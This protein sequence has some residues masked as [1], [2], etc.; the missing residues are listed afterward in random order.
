MSCEELFPTA[1]PTP[2]LPPV[3]Q[4]DNN[5]VYTIKAEGEEITVHVT[6][7]ID[8]RVVIPEA[9]EAWLSVADTRAAQLREET[10]TFIVAKNE[11]FENRTANVELIDAENSVLQTISFIQNGEA[12]IFD[13][14]SENRYVIAAAGGSVDVNVTTN[15]DYNVV[16]AESEQSWLS[17]ADTRA[18]LREHTLTIIVAPNTTYEERKATVQFV[19]DNNNVLKRILFVQDGSRECPD[20]EIRYA[21]G[22]TTVPTEISSM[23]VFGAN[24][25]SH[26][27]DAEKKC[28]II[29][30]DGDVTAI[31][32]FAFSNCDD[33]ISMAIPDS[34]DT[35]GYDAFTYCNN[36]L[37][38][39]IPEGV[40]TI[41]ES[42]FWDCDSLT[43]ITIPNSV[44]TIGERVFGGCDSLSKFNGKFAS[45]D[46]KCLIADGTLVAFA[47]GCGATE[48]TISN[49][50]T[51]IGDLAFGYCHSL[52][53]VTIPNSVTAI[54]GNPFY[55]C[56]NIAEFKGKFAS[57]DGRCLMADG[58]LIAFAV[59]CGDAVY[60]IPDGVTTIGEQSFEGCDSL[61]SVIIP[62]SVTIIEDYAFSL[63]SNLITIII[64]EGVTSIGWD[65][66]SLCVS[67][68]SVYCK[69]IT[70]PSGGFLMFDYNASD[71]KIYVPMESVEAYKA[72]EYWSEY[73]DAIV[74]YEF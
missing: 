22:S 30:F 41:G 15:L 50:V 7:D 38:V 64:P 37:T 44:T 65:A 1:E 54:E 67:L 53:N 28:W 72:A 62:E 61:L 8:Y 10:L 51:T 39:A 14:D 25:L 55:D 24:I 49:S 4:T 66:F 16:I 36:L 18:T 69:A 43:S 19:D 63:C 46:G 45:E 13:A 3:F 23:D 17:V 47:V 33:L 20:N 27:Y 11:T 31:G 9:A 58:T 73:A 29:K 21:N 56:D 59:G 32:N 42:A 35:I 52:T 26:T 70:P 2:N 60:I 34:V 48:Y 71:R 6:T 68:N 12:K 5:G 40:T 57:E 74:G